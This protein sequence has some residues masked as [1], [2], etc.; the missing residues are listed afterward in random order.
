M[1]AAASVYG[2]SRASSF[3]ISS[4]CRATCSDFFEYQMGPNMTGDPYVHS[5]RCSLSLSLSLLHEISC[6]INSPIFDPVHR[7]S[8]GETD[9]PFHL[10]PNMGWKG[11]K[12]YRRFSSSTRVIPFH[13]DIYRY[14]NTVPSAAAAAAS[15]SRGNSNVATHK[16]KRVILYFYS[17]KIHTT[18]HDRSSSGGGSSDSNDGW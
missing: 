9:T 7:P 17:S 2:H 3:L 14:S 5:S 4:F 10:H 13:S 11:A 12:K 16:R 15:K 18:R 1:A 8:N 6:N